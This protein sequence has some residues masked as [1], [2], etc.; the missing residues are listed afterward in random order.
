MHHSLW[1]IPTGKVMHHLCR[2]HRKVP[3]GVG[4]EE[5][6]LRLARNID[7]LHGEGE[8]RASYYL[9]MHYGIGGEVRLMHHLTQCSRAFIDAPQPNAHHRSLMHQNDRVS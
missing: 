8:I 5:S 9:V 1:G 3:E 2:G 6:W 4:R 7:A